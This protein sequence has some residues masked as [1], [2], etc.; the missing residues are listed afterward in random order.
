MLQ[1]VGPNADFGIVQ[2]IQADIARLRKMP[3]LAKKIED[4]QPQPDP[5]EV[6]KQKLEV[7]LLKAQIQNEL[8]KAAENQANANMDNAKAEQ[9][10][11]QTDLQDLEYLETESGVKQERELEKAGAQ[12]AAQARLRA[13]DHA[14]KMK[15]GEAK[16]NATKV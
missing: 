5:L 14:F 7:E 13:V 16:S 6:E 11:S 2:M 1:T 15:E 10:N 9:I 3:E 4:Y 8:A 12:S